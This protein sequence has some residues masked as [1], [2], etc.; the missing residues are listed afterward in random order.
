MKR[1][2]SDQPPTPPTS[3]DESKTRARLAQDASELRALLHRAQ[4]LLQGA[5]LG[6]ALAPPV[7]EVLVA[8]PITDERPLPQRAQ[9]ISPRPVRM[10]ISSANELDAD[11]EE[12]SESVSIDA[13]PDTFFTITMGTLL[14]T[15]GR[16][17]DA[18]AVFARVIARD[19]SDAEAQEGLAR[20]IAMMSA[21]PGTHAGSHTVIAHPA[22]PA[23]PPEVVAALSS[24]EPDGLLE[25]SDPPV[26]YDVDEIRALPV[27]PTTVVVFWEL[28]QSSLAR[29]QTHAAGKLMLRVVSISRNS[30]TGLP[31]MSE[32]MEGPV[33]RVG[34]WFVWGL[35]PDAT[36]EI[37]VG[38]V[39]ERA[40]EPLLAALPVQT[41]R[42]APTRARAVVQGRIALPTRTK[43]AAAE[44]P[45]I[46][47]LMG[48]Q[49]TL[50]ALRDAHGTHALS[51]TQMHATHTER[52]QDEAPTSSAHQ[53]VSLPW[54]DHAPTQSL[55]ATGEAAELDALLAH[56]WQGPMPGSMS[57][58][59]R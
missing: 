9:L 17:A 46:V 23:R 58:S 26:G 48:P 53:T 19:P 22:L 32:R 25:R 57:R 41:A 8:E 16:L 36:H 24:K 55:D 3:H 34:D 50:H 4:Q 12:K 45:R 27:D 47:A 30:R 14:L 56:A 1:N 31:Q 43:V 7:P 33:G 40:F 5:P 21:G 37:A 38:L 51:Q 6:E 39:R 11:L 20:V 59:S 10:E 42:G 44:S 28:R 29:L 18:R 54:W 52:P 15:Q 49:P 13:L 35:L 2:K